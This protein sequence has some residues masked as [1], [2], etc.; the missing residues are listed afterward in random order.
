MFKRILL[1]GAVL[2]S[3]GLFIT[4]SAQTQAPTPEEQ[5][6]TAT[7]TRQAVFKLLGYNLGVISGMARG[8]VEFDA[9]I[10]ARNAERIAALAPMIPELFG[11][12][13]RE[14]D[15]Q[16]EAL[17]VIWENMDEFEQKT[18]NLIEA[19]NTFAELARAG[20]QRATIGG[21]R[22]LGASCANCHDTFRVDD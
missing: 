5:A 10:A 15:V 21:I 19:A 4:A 9:D 17:P 22:A 2:A 13:T 1:G 7:S 8:A 6:A 12:D 14:F 18:Q 20:D 16:T 3:A 11:A